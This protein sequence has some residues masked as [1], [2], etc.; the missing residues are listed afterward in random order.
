M[1][2]E[3]N[4]TAT[5]IAFEAE[6]QNK[7]WMNKTTKIT[8]IYLVPETVCFCSLA[9]KVYPQKLIIQLVVW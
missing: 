8:F 4:W 3:I 2:T 6:K 7:I 1:A 9:I 5:F